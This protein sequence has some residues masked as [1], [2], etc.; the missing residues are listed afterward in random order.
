M[1]NCI[2]SNAYA[3]HLKPWLTFRLLIFQNELLYDID[4][5]ISQVLRVVEKRNYNA[6]E[7]IDD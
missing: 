1:G 5:N 7:F 6:L 3:K 2:T 4:G